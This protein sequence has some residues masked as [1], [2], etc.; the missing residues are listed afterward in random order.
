MCLT[1]L[2]QGN[3]AITPRPGFVCD[4]S[5]KGICNGKVFDDRDINFMVGDFQ[6]VGIPQGLNRALCYMDDGG[7]SR[8]R[9]CD[10]M[11]F[12]ES[13]CQKLAIPPRSILYY[14][15]TIKSCE[16]RKSASVF[17][18]F[19]EKMEHLESLKKKANE[20]L[21]VCNV[22]LDKSFVKYSKANIT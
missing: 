20:C 7:K 12:T 16:Q 4:I 2:E 13:E 1:R 11:S 8:I 5:I 21:K 22:A 10:A 9:I 6:D 15:V 19:A 14:F 3:G 18:T 17:N